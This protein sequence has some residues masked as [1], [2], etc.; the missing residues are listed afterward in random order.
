M[1]VA[2]PIRTSE[3]TMR[4]RETT[5]NPARFKDQLDESFYATGWG[6]ALA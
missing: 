2:A 6:P 3:I 5:F 1:P 4:D